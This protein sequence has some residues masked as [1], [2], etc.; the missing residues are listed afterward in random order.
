MFNL[1]SAAKGKLDDPILQE[2]AIRFYSKLPK[3]AQTE[4][5][6]IEVDWFHEF[7]LAQIIERGDTSFLKRLFRALPP[8]HFS[9]LK[10][11]ISK[12]WTTWS[13]STVLEAADVLAVIAPD[14]LI[15]LYLEDLA[16][17]KHGTK[18]DPLRFSSINH[19]P[20]DWDNASLSELTTQLINN[21]PAWQD[22]VSKALLISALLNFAKQLDTENLE[23]LLEA[24]LQLETSENRRHGIFRHLFMGLFDHDDYLEMVFDREEYES[25]LRLVEL[26]AFFK[27]S[28]PLVQ[29]DTWLKK[30]PTSNDILP[31]LETL[32]EESVGCRI[33]LR[34]LKDSKRITAKLST[35]SQAQLVLAA[36][37]HGYAKSA[38]EIATF[39]VS[40][41]L[42]LLSIDL[43]EPRW[44]SLLTQHL[45]TL[46]A[47]VVS[48]ALITR[49]RENY[50][51][52]AA[53]NVAEVMGE[54]AYPEFIEP[55][56]AAIGENKGDFICEAARLALSNIGNPAQAT[57]IALW[58]KL[59]RSQKIFGLSIIQ[60]SHNQ[61][62]IDFATSRFSELLNDDMESACELILASPSAALLELLKPELRR[63][64][65]LLDRAFYIS[66]KLLDYEDAEVDAAKERAF[67]EHQRTEQLFASFESGY[68]PQNDHLFLDLECS[69]CGAVNR[70]QAKGVVVTADDNQSTLLADEF[71]CASCNEYVEFN[72]TS[73]A[74]MAVF[75]ELVKLTALNK[76]DSSAFQTIKTMDC[77]LDGQVMPLASA[78]ATVR[79][80]LNT[81]PQNA[82]EWLRL[83]N[84]LSNLHRPKAS[85]KA[86]QNA[87]KFAPT[88]VDAQFALAHTLT[89]H[90]QE[91]N[92]FKQLQTA[93]EQS[94]N[95]SF[96]GEFP[97]FG[98]AFA[99]LY[100]HLRR[101]LG[102][103]NIPSLHPSAFS[104]P[105]KLGRN[106]PCSCGS[107]KKYKKCCGS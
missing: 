23:F 29:F 58:D 77:R 43:E 97:N 100:N 79:S 101:Q 99:D 16:K 70:Y 89:E 35:K 95:W 106:D 24:A 21:I 2:W 59:D 13:A 40:A 92:A 20:T 32:K 56:I 1:I 78:I 6:Q 96:L 9:S 39:D 57:L 73:M 80:R 25:P 15:Q 53:V 66:A 60:S 30:L 28:A 44:N 46:D 83:G 17:F 81:D 18:I 87:I 33:G 85:I 102:K 52:F 22:P 50:D 72:F 48:A 31:L 62:T 103:N 61:A 51:D 10:H 75:A 93:L 69:V 26:A 41:T 94:A 71:P 5:N 63:K 37:I 76:G 45:K 55:L 90:Q 84:L 49:L 104:S 64:Q 74:K 7:F 4:R 65:S 36:C 42:N 105:K 27:D 68:L 11:L 54:L 3:N 88:A 82:R 98:N 14:Q 19:I 107:G 47:S 8:Q 12:N 91:S 67:A 34:L 86:Y 38:L